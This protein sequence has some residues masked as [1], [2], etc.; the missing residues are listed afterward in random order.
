LSLRS[1]VA[2]NNAS[3]VPILV[4]QASSGLLHA[5]ANTN[6][7]VV[8][9]NSALL[10]QYLATKSATLSFALSQFLPNVL[11]KPESCFQGFTPK[12]IRDLRRN[13]F[14][15]GE[16]IEEASEDDSEDETAVLQSKGN[17]IA[18]LAIITPENSGTARSTDSVSRGTAKSTSRDNVIS[19]EA[20]AKSSVSINAKMETHV[21]EIEEAPP[22]V[23]YILPHGVRTKYTN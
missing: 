9:R 7:T 17:S 14:Q 22:V 21:E 16:S 11:T 4:K 15:E 2:A 19:R 10:L 20:I 5:L 8:Q 13:T 6:N 23:R 18:R 3:V 1:Y 12:K